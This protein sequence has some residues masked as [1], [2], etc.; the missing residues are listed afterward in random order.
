MQNMQIINVRTS[1]L[2]AGIMVRPCDYGAHPEWE[3][4]EVAGHGEI[5]GEA[6][7]CEPGTSLTEFLVQMPPIAIMRARETSMVSHYPPSNKWTANPIRNLV[8]GGQLVE[9]ELRDM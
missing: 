6:F 2:Y 9:L 7:R 5:L 3:V 1:G 4:V 8:N